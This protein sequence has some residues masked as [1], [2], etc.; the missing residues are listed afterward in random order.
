MKLVVS[1]VLAASVLPAWQATPP[2]TGAYQQPVP[3][4]GA[5]WKKPEGKPLPPDKPLA[6]VDGET[7]TVAKLTELLTGAPPLALNSAASNPG[8][9]LTWTHLLSKMSAEGQ[10]L[11]LDKKSPYSDRLKWNSSQVLMMA[12]L[13][14]KN[15]ESAPDEKEIQVLYRENPHRYGIAKTKLIFVPAGPTA[16]ATMDLVVAQARKGVD[17]VKLV[18]QH[19]ADQDSAAKD[20]DFADITPDSKVPEAI[21][22]TI[23][24]TK[25]G[26]L[27]P[28][29]PQP[30]G[31][32][33]FKV[34]AV[35]MRPLEDVAQET[36][37][38]TGQQRAVEWMEAEKKKASVKIIHEA[39]FKSLNVT[40]G[41][42]LSRGAQDINL[43]AT[44][45]TAEIT[46]TTV[47]AE[48]NGKPMTAA[49]YTNLIKSL[50]PQVRTKAV[51]APSDFLKDYAF[52]LRLVDD[53]ARLGLDK[54]QPY[55]NRLAYD[56]DMALMQAAVDEYLNN[57]V[58][59][60][61][62]QKAA[63]A[64]DPNK[65]RFATTRVLYIAYSLTPP[66]QTD[67]NAKKILNEQEA[68]LK[69]EGILKDI[70]EKKDDFPVYVARYSEDEF[71]RNEGGIMRPITF[72][73]PEVPDPVKLPIF[74]AK[75]GDIVG[76]VKLANGYYLFKVDKIETR[77][78]DDVKDQIYEELRQQRFQE[79]FNQQRASIKVTVEDPDGFRHTVAFAR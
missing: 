2:A 33:L 36:G 39:F 59:S 56:R 48:I 71:S 57:I 58:V 49:E 40:A 62:E 31:L 8:E 19:S 30:A 18:K 66:P 75:E 63:F 67:P 24:T 22:K 16:K 60:V 68:R 73:D 53:A 45:Q 64:A 43:L 35:N 37:S 42:M 1:L 51:V 79:W 3:Q 25:P 76:P 21:R 70:R 5:Q 41:P 32:Y 7:I 54:K 17:F 28:V 15:R 13:E 9:F 27:T 77:K 10:K 55:K 74:A 44:P 46:P 47:L 14:E 23:F 34:T 12:R 78:Y 72:L 6:H 29:I 20:G 50:S 4:P 26:Q 69:I 52:M 65:F 38:L 11:G 61:A